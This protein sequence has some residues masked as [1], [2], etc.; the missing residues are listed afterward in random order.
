[1]GD[2]DVD[3]VHPLNESDH[4]LLVRIS[5]QLKSLTVRFDEASTRAQEQ[6]RQNSDRL[7]T[8]DARLRKLE[9]WRWGWTAAV[10]VLV[11][12]ITLFWRLVIR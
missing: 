12:L 9:E 2:G 11:F 10:S 4:D 6:H 8:L 7:T 3:A 1:M 5:E